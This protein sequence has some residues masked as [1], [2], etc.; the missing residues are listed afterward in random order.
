MRLTS[1][2]HA[3][4][5]VA[6]VTQDKPVTFRSSFSRR[7]KNLDLYT[8]TYWYGKIALKAIWVIE[9]GTERR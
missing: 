3:L 7:T 2:K 8:L 9:D 5:E 4:N 6:D 1:G